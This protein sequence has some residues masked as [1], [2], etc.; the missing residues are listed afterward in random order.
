MPRVRPAD[1]LERLIA[2]ATR[3]F[4]ASG[5]F[6]RTQIGDVARAMGVAKGTVY[7]Y[8]ES[9]EALFDLV[10]RR[11]LGLAVHPESL[12]VPTPAPGATLEM[13][14]EHIREGSAFPALESGASLVD[15]LGEIYDVLEHNR[16]AIK[17]IGTSAHDMPELAEVWLGQGRARL[18]Q[19]LADYLGRRTDTVAVVDDVDV[20][21]RL[22]S[23]TLTWFAVH[24]HF[25]PAPQAMSATVARATAIGILARGV[26]GDR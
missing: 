5:G 19:R 17:L 1:R 10:M 9:K 18:N 22:I 8:V 2:T 23:E 21:A 13:V 24:R 7:L 16:T 12:P 4:V 15:V 14:A 26:G 11:A 6:R 20:A 3:V 25:D